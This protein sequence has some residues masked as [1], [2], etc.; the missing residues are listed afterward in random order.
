MA[1]SASVS[2]GPWVGGLNTYS[3]QT[4]VADNE[5]VVIENFELDLD[6]SLLSRPPIVDTGVPFPLQD[7]GNLTLL[8]YY[9]APGNVPYLIASD[10]KSKTY[11]FTGSN[12]VLLTDTI[13]ATAMVQFNDRAWMLA[14]VG[15]ANKGGY[16]TPDGGFVA[17]ANMPKGDVLV[18]MKSRLWVATGR[19]ATTQGTRLYY[20]KTLGTSPFWAATPD[21]LDVGVGDG[22]NIVAAAVYYNALLI[23]RTDSVYSFSYQS[24][25]SS[26]VVNL[27]LPGVGLASKDC[28]VANE[29]YLY[30]LYEEKAYEFVNNRANRLNDKVPFT[31]TSKT[32]IYKP[33]SVST[34]NNRIIF[35]YYDTLY[36]FNLR[37]RTW[38]TWKSPT[39]GA[40]GQLYEVVGTSQSVAI[41]HSSVAV[42]GATR[43]AKTLR[44]TDGVSSDSETYQCTL[45]TKNYSYEATGVFKRLYWWG[46][47]AV[48]RGTV[49]ATANP[50]VFGGTVTWADLLSH[51]WA[52]V[53][54]FNW[55]QPLNPSISVETVRDT[56][57]TSAVRKFVKFMKS[58]RFRQINYKVVFDTDGSINS[59]P[60][61]LFKL[62]TT[63][64]PKEHVSRTVS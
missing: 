54:Q 6:G 16:W 35:S 22:Q 25:P 59:A 63:V 33:Y 31:A 48:F 11:Y 55:D 51:T 64:R 23:F 58:L 50:I 43:K 20:S 45:Q 61:R 17:D 37:T 39:N 60:V 24:D 26:G 34:F 56:T 36:V 14:P 40:I 8:G 2:I 21:Y 13:S 5:A 10:G 42:T 28:L 38:T 46:A 9:N 3:D 57:G 30:F 27:V 47:D 7:T 41:T 4:A 12:W 49:R 44:I 32:G 52:E 29:S 53:R 18:S 19:S 1:A 62:D 15:S